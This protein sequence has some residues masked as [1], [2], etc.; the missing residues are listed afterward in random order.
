MRGWLASAV[1]GE[2]ERRYG[3]LQVSDK[4]GGSEFT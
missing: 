3:I 2:G 1:F 4:V